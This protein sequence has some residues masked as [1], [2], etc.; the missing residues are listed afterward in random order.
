VL[1][2]QQEDVYRYLSKAPDYCKNIIQMLAGKVNSLTEEVKR[3]LLHRV[4]KSPVD[5]EV[6]HRISPEVLLVLRSLFK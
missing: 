3:E 2:I 4:N 5:C 1:V 6:I